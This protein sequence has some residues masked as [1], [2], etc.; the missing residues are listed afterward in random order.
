M[1]IGVVFPQ[2]EIGTT[3]PAIR[4]YARAV[5]AMGFTHILAYDHV[6]G[7]STTRRP[8]WN[9]PYTSESV[10]H[11]IFVLFGYLA[12]VTER[13]ELVTGVVVLPRRQAALVAKQ[14]AEVDVLSGGRLRL[15][16]GVGWSE[17]EYEGLDV[18]FHHRGARCDEQIQVLR[19][20]WR[21]HDVTFTGRW[22]R[23]EG[24]GMAP[25]PV[26]RAIPIWIG[27]GAEAT[28]RRVARLGDGWFPELMPDERARGMLERLRTHARAAGRDPDALGIE[29]RL[30]LADVRDEADWRRFAEGWRQLG[31]THLSVNTLELGLASPEAHLTTLQ[32]V[33]AALDALSG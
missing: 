7:A 10:F 32:R 21:E 14:A 16:V 3:A 33:K 30:D 15:G 24:V 25:L 6:L 18:D 13:I 28:L 4:E 11:E 17:V 12:A 26:H 23:M 1:R 8:S 9:G 22:H 19:A 31:A 2:T 20:L 5:E 27:G 29:A